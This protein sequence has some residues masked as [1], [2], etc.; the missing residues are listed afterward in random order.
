MSE[1]EDI[2]KCKNKLYA[3]LHGLIRKFPTLD[4]ETLLFMYRSYCLPLY[5]MNLWYNMHCK[6]AKRQLAVAYHSA[7]KKIFKVPIRVS[8]HFICAA[9]DMLV[10][11]HFA[12]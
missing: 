7:I 3:G 9:S 8:N 4:S 2:A 6:V 11:K 12:N 5:G 10:F 1:K